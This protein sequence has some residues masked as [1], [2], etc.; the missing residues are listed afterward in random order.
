MPVALGGFVGRWRF[1]VTQRRRL[2]RIL[3]RLEVLESTALE[4]AE[5]ANQ[6]SARGV[7]QALEERLAAHS[8]GLG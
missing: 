3:R 6:S 7:L 2:E 5:L 4:A 8:P 1:T